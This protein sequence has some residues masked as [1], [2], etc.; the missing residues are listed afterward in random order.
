VVTA[1]VFSPDGKLVASASGDCTVRLWDPAT[2]ESCGVL[3]GHS[4]NVN[5][6]VFSP[7]GK[8]VAS[9][10]WDTT[11]RLWDPATGESCGVLKGH[12]HIVNAVVFS[13]DGKLVASASGDCTVRLWDPVTGESCGVLKGHSHIVNAVVFS[14]DGKLV[15]SASE[16]RTIRLWNPATGESC[17]V[18]KGHSYN[19]NTV[20]FSPDGKLVASA[21]NDKT[22]RLWDVIQKTTIEEIH[23]GASIRR[24][25]F[26]DRIQLD[27]DWGMLT[28]TPQ[29]HPSTSTQATFPSSIYVTHD[30]WVT[31]NKKRILFL[32]IDYRP[33]ALQVKDNILVMKHRSGCVTFTHFNPTAFAL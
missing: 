11:V 12:S 10:S 2:G 29:L 1:V 28:L 14:P 24:L 26:T 6:V 19:V 33:S 13:P 23:T 21:S 16:D 15:A 30:G 5:A 27:T 18:L 20:V 32:P 9:A 8:L 25:N 4:Y 22:V 31:W 7:D 17:G 3:K